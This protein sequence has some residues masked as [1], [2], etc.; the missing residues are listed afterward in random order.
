MASKRISTPP[1]DTESAKRS[2]SDST[3]PPDIEAAERCKSV[4]PVQAWVFMQSFIDNA[5]KRSMEE[6]RIE[7]LN[8]EIGS[9]EKRNEEL[10]KE[11]ES[12]EAKNTTHHLLGMKKQLQNIQEIELHRPADAQFVKLLKSNGYKGKFLVL[13]Y[14]VPIQDAMKRLNESFVIITP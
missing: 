2:K 1:L 7:E 9:V 10:N 12:I 5:V 4:A 6:K 14:A 11:I 13:D 3:T 8:K